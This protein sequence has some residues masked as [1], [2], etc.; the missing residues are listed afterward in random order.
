[1]HKSRRNVDYGWTF[2]VSSWVCHWPT[3]EL[4]NITEP[5]YPP[6]AEPQGALTT[7]VCERDKMSLPRK[8]PDMEDRGR[9]Q[10]WSSSIQVCKGG[11]EMARN[12]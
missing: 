7:N 6:G 5:L 9:N 12:S 3:S 1:M 10:K 2:R 4:E 8:E 11:W